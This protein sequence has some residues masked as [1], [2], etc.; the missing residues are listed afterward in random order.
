MVYSL[1]AKRINVK[2]L[3]EELVI[4]RTASYKKVSVS[5]LHR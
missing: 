3:D 2:Y 4:N 5:L 1:P